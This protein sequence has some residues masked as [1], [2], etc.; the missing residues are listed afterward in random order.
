[1]PITHGYC[2]L[3]DIKLRI[4]LDLSDTTKDAILEAIITAVSRQIEQET[5]RRFWTATETRTYTAQRMDRCLI[6]DCL[7]V[8]TLKTDI[9]GLRLYDTTWGVND[10]DLLPSNAPLENGGEPY[11]EL[12]VRLNS[13]YVFPVGIPLSV[14]VTGIFGY[15]ATAPDQVREAA[16]IQTIRLLKRMDAP[17]GVIGASEFGQALVIAK[18]DPDVRYLLGPFRKIVVT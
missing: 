10:F 13:N 9:T 7:S 18:L 17:F 4:G 1:M 11:W 5:Q 14:Q 2:S 6:D 16:I 3:Q 12:S 15:S 8:T